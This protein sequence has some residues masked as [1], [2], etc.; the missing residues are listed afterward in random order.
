LAAY[1]LRDVGGDLDYIYRTTGK[2]PKESPS[3]ISNHLSE[4]KY[5]RD[6]FDEIITDP[7]KHFY[8]VGQKFATLKVVAGM[9]KNRNEQKDIDDISLISSLRK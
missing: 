2:H 7:A 5:F 6:S 1:G 9:K 8:Y 4:H 3:R